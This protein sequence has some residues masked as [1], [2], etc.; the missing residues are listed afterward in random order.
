MCYPRT[1]IR[2]NVNT[3]Y[4]YFLQKKWDRSAPYEIRE[5]TASP[6]PG[7]SGATIKAEVTK[8]D[9][10]DPSKRHAISRAIDTTLG[11]PFLSEYICSG[12][13]EQTTG[14]GSQ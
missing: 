14:S 8:D 1:N 2:Y 7:S 4:I 12:N 11:E 10:R 6:V 13:K 5:Q 9:A 3:L